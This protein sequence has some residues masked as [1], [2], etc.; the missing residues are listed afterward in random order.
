MTRNCAAVFVCFLSLAGTAPGQ[1]VALEQ[2]RATLDRV[3]SRAKD[4]LATQGATPDLTTAKRQLRDWVDSY[5]TRMAGGGESALELSLNEKLAKA[6]LMATAASVGGAADAVG[7]SMAGFLGE[8]KIRRR[9]SLLAVTTGIGIV[10]GFDESIYIYRWTAGKWKRIFDYEQ[11]DYREGHYLPQHVIDVLASPSDKD[12]PDLVMSLGYTPWCT[13]NWRADYLRIWSIDGEAKHQTLVE[14]NPGGFSPWFYL[15]GTIDRDQALVE[16]MTSSLDASQ[17]TRTVLHRYV[18]ED[19]KAVRTDPIAL[20]PADFAD[21]WLSLDWEEARRWSDPANME[22]LRKWHGKLRQD[23][24]S[25]EFIRPSRHCEDKPGHWAVG[26]DSDSG[27]ANSRKVYFLVQW[28]P[29][30]RFR[31]V[32]VSEQSPPGCTEPDPDGDRS[33]GSLFHE[34]PVQ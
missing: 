32:Q 4:A 14:T 2:L 8:A 24:F 33:V 6:G 30:F 27:E 29:P 9:N 18:F 13:S 5:V 23:R 11:S 22:V 16:A 15:K 21:E 7:E 10:C 1:D 28:R 20:R 31:M 17:L 19:G 26:V 3:K 25:G 12:R 34:W